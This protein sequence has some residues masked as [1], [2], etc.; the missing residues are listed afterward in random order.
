MKATNR[1]PP[2]DHEGDFA[3]VG[4]EYGMLYYY[5]VEWDG[6]KLITNEGKE[7]EDPSR[8]DDGKSRIFC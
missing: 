3:I 5:L 6:D 4:V 1:L 7:L 8:F 2:K